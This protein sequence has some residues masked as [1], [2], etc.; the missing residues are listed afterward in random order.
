[1][2]AGQNALWQ[3]AIVG[4][5]IMQPFLFFASSHPQLAD[6]NIYGMLDDLEVP[7]D[8]KKRRRSGGKKKKKSGRPGSAPVAGGA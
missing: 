5:K 2:C 3:T 1:M 8:K 7:L 6:D 4:A